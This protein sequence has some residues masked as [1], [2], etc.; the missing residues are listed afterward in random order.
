VIRLNRDDRRRSIREELDEPHKAIR[1][2]SNDVTKLTAAVHAL[3]QYLRERFHALE[4]SDEVARKLTHELSQ[5][6]TKPEHD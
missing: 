3:S 1:S 6:N 5:L 4:A 2:M